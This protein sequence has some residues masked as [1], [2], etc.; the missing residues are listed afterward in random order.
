[1]GAGEWGWGWGWGGVS[2]GGGG[3]EQGLGSGGGGWSR[4]AA[5]GRVQMS[6][7]HGHPSHR[8]GPLESTPLERAWLGFGLGL[9]LGLE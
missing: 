2:V 3:G 9:G 5:Y 4:G 1:M 7:R 8:V 6:L